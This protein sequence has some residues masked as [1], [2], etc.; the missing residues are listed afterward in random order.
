MCCVAKIR[1]EERC[2]WRVR[3]GIG[4][5]EDVLVEVVSLGLGFLFRGVFVLVFYRS[6]VGGFFGG[7][8]VLEIVWEVFFFGFDVRRCLVYRVG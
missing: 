4:G 6:G 8:W 3:L 7:T 5:L 2:A 1:V